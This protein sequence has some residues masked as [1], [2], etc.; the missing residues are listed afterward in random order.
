MDWPMKAFKDGTL[1]ITRHM[2]CPFCNPERRSDVPTKL[3][4]CKDHLWVNEYWFR[5]NT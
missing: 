3:N 2:N 1:K 4:A 5:E